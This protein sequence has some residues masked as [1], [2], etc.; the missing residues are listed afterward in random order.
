MTSL[1][2][3]KFSLLTVAYSTGCFSFY[4]IFPPM[5]PFVAG[6]LSTKLVI[7]GRCEGE[8]GIGRDFLR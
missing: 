5:Q 1:P 7:D 3:N 4:I 6:P 8:G 2:E